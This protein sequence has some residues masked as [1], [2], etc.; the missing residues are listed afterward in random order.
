MTS[1]RICPNVNV[2]TGTPYQD[3]GWYGGDPIQ[4]HHTWSIQ[5]NDDQSQGDCSEVFTDQAVDFDRKFGRQSLWGLSAWVD[6][7]G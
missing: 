7:Q 1:D 6:A 3:W 4:Y 2:D 5:W